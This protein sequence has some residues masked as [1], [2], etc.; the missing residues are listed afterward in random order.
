[1]FIAISGLLMGLVGC[2]LRDEPPPRPVL[3]VYCGITMIGAMSDVA[4]IVEQEKACTIRITKGG[5]GNLLRAIE[6]NRE[7]DLYLPGSDSYIQQAKEKG[8]IEQF[9]TVGENRAAIV[10][11]KG[12][13]KNIPNDPAIFTNANLKAIFADPNSGSIGQMAGEIF[14]QRGV[15]DAAMLQVTRISTDSKDI[16]TAV[17]SGE[18][19]MGINWYA[20]T[21]WAENCDEL[22]AVLM[23]EQ[24]APPKKLVLGRLTVSQHPEIAAFFI[25][26][27]SGPRGKEIFERHGF[28]SLKK[29]YDSH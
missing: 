2:D 23:D 17:K 10:V 13:P 28:R 7:G 9:A 19:D 15:L 6:V 12:N 4:R 3:T 26:T 21:C 18:V 20:T 5:S 1:M 27:A 11:P 14:K 8:L 24:F 22:D 16:T 29:E 25:Q